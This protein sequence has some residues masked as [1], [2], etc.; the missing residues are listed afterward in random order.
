MT[1]DDKPAEITLG[2]LRGALEPFICGQSRCGQRMGSFHGI[3]FA[4]H[5]EKIAAAARK[6]LPLDASNQREIEVRLSR[7]KTGFRELAA[8]L[9]P[10]QSNAVARQIVDAA[11]VMSFGTPESLAD[12]RKAIGKQIAGA[13][14]SPLTDAINVAFAALGK[15]ASGKLILKHIKEQQGLGAVPSTSLISKCRELISK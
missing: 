2:N 10:T 5:L 13:K 4:D 8:V 12:L 3:T 9:E 6:T 14:G 11:F 15:D 1:D 7:F